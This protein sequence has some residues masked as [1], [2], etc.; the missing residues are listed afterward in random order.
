[1]IASIHKKVNTTRTLSKNPTNPMAPCPAVVLELVPQK[2]QKPPLECQLPGTE[3]S[4]INASR[5][6]RKKICLYS[7]KV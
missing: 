6:L 7:Q 5:L 1:M 3:I 4:V 2:T